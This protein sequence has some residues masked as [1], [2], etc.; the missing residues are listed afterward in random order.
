[1]AEKIFYLQN[2]Q[3]LFATVRFNALTVSLHRPIDNNKTSMLIP[4]Y[5]SK[6][7]QDTVNPDAKLAE[8]N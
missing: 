5:V 2:N 8:E 7:K 4:F 6:K 1:M 3:S